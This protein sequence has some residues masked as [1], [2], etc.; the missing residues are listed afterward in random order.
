M[1]NTTDQFSGCSFGIAAIWQYESLKS[2]MHNYLEDIRADW[3]EKIR[4][5]KHGNFRKQV[6]WIPL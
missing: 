3:L 4:P 1:L 2:R 6:K 5:P